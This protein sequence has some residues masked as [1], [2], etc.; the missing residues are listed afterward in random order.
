MWELA[1]CYID[2]KPTI[3]YFKEENFYLISKFENNLIEN[4][5]DLLECNVDCGE[6]FG[7][8]DNYLSINYKVK[9]VILNANNW[10]FS[11]CTCKH[12]F[13]Y[14]ICKHIITIAVKNKLAS[15]DYSY[16]NIGEKKK[17]G[18]QAKAK[19]CLIRQI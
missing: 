4:Y 13:K 11:S 5:Y 1:A 16:Q 6:C 7:D 19:S 2:E 12:F 15:I 18:R 8:L 17:R 9:K 3:N 14:Y 10:L